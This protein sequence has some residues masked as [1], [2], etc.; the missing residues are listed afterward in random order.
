MKICA[1]D[2]RDFQAVGS[3]P[4]SRL[5]ALVALVGVVSPLMSKGVASNSNVLLRLLWN[6]LTKA[7]VGTRKSLSEPS[8]R[9]VNIRVFWLTSTVTRGGLQSVALG[10]AGNDH[11]SE[12]ILLGLPQALQSS[13]GGKVRNPKVSGGL[14]T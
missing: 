2:T 7:P 10:G 6:E 13:H 11:P 5:L 3:L 4:A 14:G 1:L 12:I 9:S 8:I